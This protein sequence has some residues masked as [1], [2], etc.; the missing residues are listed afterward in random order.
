MVQERL[1][2]LMLIAI[3]QEIAVHIDVDAVIDDF[4]N[5]VDYKRRMTL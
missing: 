5:K 4:K 3:E 1:N 2:S